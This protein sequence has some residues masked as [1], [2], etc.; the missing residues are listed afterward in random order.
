MPGWALYVLGGWGP[1][2]A[3]LLLTR[4]KA[5]LAAVADLAGRLLAWR[6]GARWYAV[7]L[8]GA[9]K[10]RWRWPLRRTRRRGHAA[11][12]GRA[13]GDGA[14]G[15]GRWRRAAG[16]LGG[17]L[18]VAGFTA[19]SLVG[20][21]WW[22]G[23]RAA[24]ASG[25]PQRGRASLILGI[26]WGACTCPWRWRRPPLGRGAHPPGPWYL[27]ENI[28]RGDILLHLGGQTLPREP[29][30]GTLIHTAGN[31]VSYYLPVATLAEGAARGTW[32]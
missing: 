10:R 7:A 1:A 5:A 25:A 14:A 24:G 15:D 26:M 21:D 13:G 29:A 4:G 9:R 22:R 28:N 27:L 6:V 12:P 20:E 23:V 16:G 18:L 17:A 2:L 32:R 3:A 11:G 19:V 30:P 8:V 31:V